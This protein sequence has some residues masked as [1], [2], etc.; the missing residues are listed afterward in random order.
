MAIKRAK[1]SFGVMVENNGRVTPKVIRSGDLYEDSDPIV[2]KYQDNF[3]DVEVHV[4]QQRERRRENVEAAT[5]APGEKRTRTQPE[6]RTTRTRK[7][8]EE[9]KREEDEQ[10][11][12]DELKVADPDDPDNA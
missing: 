3:E 6:K 12:A 11:Q 7:T 2:K 8:A 4:T 10:R 1:T 9:K 5:A